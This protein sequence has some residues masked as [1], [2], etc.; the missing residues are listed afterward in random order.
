[1]EKERER[2][3]DLF[4]VNWLKQLS[5]RVSPNSVEQPK[6]GRVEIQLRGDVVVASPKTIGQ[7]S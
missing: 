1:M 7:A 2:E 5:G 4:F 6:A 3:I